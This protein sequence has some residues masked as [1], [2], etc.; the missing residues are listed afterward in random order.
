MSIHK[1]VLVV[2]FIA[3][4]VTSLALG[5]ARAA[6]AAPP[7]QVPCGGGKCPANCQSC[8][9]T[10][11]GLAACTVWCGGDSGGGDDQPPPTAPPP[12]PASPPAPG[13][14]SPPGPTTMPPPNPTPGGPTAPP[15]PPTPLP[16]ES[17]YSCANLPYCASG[18]ADVCVSGEFLISFN[19]ASA[20]ACAPPTAIPTEPPPPPPQPPC[21]PSYSGSGGGVDIANCSADGQRGFA[22]DVALSV[23]ARVPPHRVQI[24]PFPQW[25]VALGAPI[26]NPRWDEPEVDP[27]KMILMDYPDYTPPELCAPNGPGD[28]G[29][30]WSNTVDVPPL[31]EDAEPKPGDVR[32]YKIGLR[33]RRARSDMRHPNDLGSV[34]DVCWDFNERDW[35]VGEDYGYGRIPGQ[36]CGSTIVEHIYE[37]SS[38]GLPHNGPDFLPRKEACNMNNYTQ[39]ENGCCE[40]I[41]SAD[42]EW[43]APAYQIKVYTTWAAEWAVEWEAWDPVGEE[44]P[45]EGCFCRAEGEPI[46]VP[47]RPCPTEFQSWCGGCGSW[48]GQ[49]GQARYDW[50]RHFEGWHPIDLRQWGGS[51]W[52]YLS[53]AVVTT[54][55]GPWCAFEYGDPNPGD[56][57]RIPV[58]EI[59]VVLMDPCVIDD[60]CPP[61]YNE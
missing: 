4:L 61:G 2:V 13:P 23:S 60:S 55:A 31:P 19:C 9:V 36:S 11:D 49:V 27:G 21:P 40:Q 26:Y 30:C 7:C 57:V 17:C 29:G 22:W 10:D 58:F 34:P 50:V 24:D 59:Q 39:R 20:A 16:G 41:P 28:S 33:W 35:N 44:W 18:Y 5:A 14:T 51:E 32:N 12:P 8:T 45:E 6:Q 48:C 52:Y 54:G 53:Y 25:L 56:T 47:H 38:W 42:G 1:L 43:T 3:V 46:G 15:P 37:T